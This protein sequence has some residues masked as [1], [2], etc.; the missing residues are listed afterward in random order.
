MKLY[1]YFRSSASYR[2]RIVLNLKNIDYTKQEVQLVNNGGEQHNINYKQ[3]I[4]F[5]ELVPSL[6]L[7]HNNIITQSIA[8][9]EYLEDVYPEPSIYPKD[10]L[11]R[12]Q[13]KSM[14]Y[15]IA[16]DV[17]PLNNLR[18]LQYLSNNF[19]ISEQQ[20]LDWYHNW[21]IKGF[22]S[23]EYYINKYNNIGNKLANFSIDNKLSIAD[24]C[25]I[26]QVYNALRFE[27]SMNDYPNIYNIY[28]HCLQIDCFDLAK[29]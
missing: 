19:K 11:K 12:A 26:P 7:E 15:I 28:Q 23:Y 25:L 1:D 24:I 4:N 10:S 16:C 8:I 21:L 5:Q 22:D 14:A 17:H 27:L 18:V 2:V 3:D 20:K 29:P 13:A 6:V 9:I